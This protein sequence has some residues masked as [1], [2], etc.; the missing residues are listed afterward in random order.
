METIIDLIA[1]PNTVYS[2]F[3]LFSFINYIITIIN[4]ILIPT[5]A[6]QLESEV[7]KP[8]LEIIT[9]ESWMHF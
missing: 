9:C 6:K 1:F 7:L 4:N 3:Y 8:L 5:A 2:Q